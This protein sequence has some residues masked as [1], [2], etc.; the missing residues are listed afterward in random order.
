MISI[1]CDL[2]STSHQPKI[3]TSFQRHYFD[4]FS[5]SHQPKIST[6][7]QRHYFDVL[8][9][10]FFKGYDVVT[11]FQRIFDVIPTSCAHWDHDMANI[12]SHH[13]VYR[14]SL[15]ISTIII[16]RGAEDPGWEILQRPPSVPL[17]VCPS[18]CPSVHPSVRLSVTFSFRTVTQK[19]IDVFSRN[20]AG[21]CTM[22]WGCAV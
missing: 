7:F 9:T 18:V 15:S 22:S 4:V 5:T 14:Y 16:S 6:S 11:T 1:N 13:I 19:R 17:S 3:S 20:F 12:I 8:L 10:S 2:I 21:M